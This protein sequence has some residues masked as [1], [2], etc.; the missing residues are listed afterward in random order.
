M[1]SIITAPLRSLAALVPRKA[2]RETPRKKDHSSALQPSILSRAGAEKHVFDCVLLPT[3]KLARPEGMKVVTVGELTKY[4]LPRVVDFGGRD[5]NLAFRTT[6]GTLCSRIVVCSVYVDQRLKTQKAERKWRMLR[7]SSEKAGFVF[8]LEPSKPTV[9]LTAAG[10]ADTNT[11]DVDDDEEEEAPFEPPC[12]SEEEEEEVVDLAAEADEA[13]ASLAG[14]R[15]VAGSR[16]KP[17]VKCMC[18]APSNV[19]CLEKTCP[20]FGIPK[21]GKRPNYYHPEELM[22]RRVRVHGGQVKF[23]V[24]RYDPKTDEKIG[25]SMQKKHIMWKLLGFPEGYGKPWAGNDLVPGNGPWEVRALGPG[26][27]YTDKFGR[28]N[29]RTGELIHIRKD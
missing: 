2:G 16:P 15:R 1:L 24:H 18:A 27:K 4:M 13:Q 7:R 29:P 19:R 22:K 23:K 9:A 21:L 14:G 20:N 28:H 3:P 8:R 12:E 11:G 5:E 17:K 10:G 6:S 25:D 26:Q